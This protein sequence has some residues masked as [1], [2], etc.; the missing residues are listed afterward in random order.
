MPEQPLPGRARTT[1][2]SHRVRRIFMVGLGAAV[3]GGLSTTL[4]RAAPTTDLPA[5]GPVSSEHHAG[6]MVFAEL[7]T[8]D[9]VTAEQFYT[10]LFRWS[11]QNAYVGKTLF[12]QASFNG[13][14]V[15]AIVQKKLPEGRRPIWLSFMAT[16]DVDKAADLAVEHG[17]QVLMKPHQIANIGR[18]ALLTDPQGAVFGM[19][20]SSSGD[21]PDVLAQ[22]GEWIW[23][24]L[25]TP[26]PETDAAFYKAL[27]GYDELSMPDPQDAKHLILTSENYAR[28]SVNPM[29]ADHPVS[30]ARWISYVRVQDVAATTAKVTALGGRIVLAPRVDRQGSPIALVADPSGALFG[31]MQWPEDAAEGDAK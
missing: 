6:K 8:P 31:L 20:A 17:A 2:T 14:V 30:R 28:A 27:F 9:L 22:P 7:V 5:L 12:G 26:D 11:F 19:L 4:V 24:S 18:D 3:A 13:R 15:A 10:D 16:G 1:R 29:P 23:S 25:V 21:S